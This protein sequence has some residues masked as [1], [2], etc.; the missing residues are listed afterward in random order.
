MTHELILEGCAP[1]PLASYLK[2]IGVLRLVANQVDPEAIGWWSGDRFHLGS[3]LDREELERFLLYDYQPTPIVAPWNGG[4]GFY[5]KDK[6]AREKG[7]DPIVFSKCNRLELYRSILTLCQQVISN[8]GLTE[9][10]GDEIKLR[11]FVELRGDF[12]DEALDWLDAAILL[13]SDDLKFPPLLGTGGNDGRLEFTANFMQRLMSIIDPFT[14][15]PSPEATG[16]LGASLFGYARFHMEKEGIGQFLPGAIGGPNSS[17]NARGGFVVN[18]W[19]YVL[20]L[21]GAVLFAAA[22][23]RRLG[24]S[25]SATLAYP[26]TVRPTGSGSGTTTVGDDTSSRAEIWMPLWSR[27]MGIGELRALLAE[28]RATVGRRSTQDGLDFARATAA[29]G[30][31]RGVDAFERY[32]FFQRSGKAYLATPLTRVPV[33]RNPAMDLVNDLDRRQWLSRFRGMARSKD[34]PARLGRVVRRLEDALFDLARDGSPLRVQTVLAA[35]GKAQSYLAT[36]PK[37]QDKI[38]PVPRLGGRWLA[39][40]DDRSHE[41]RLAAALSGINPATLPLRAHLAPVSPDP[42]KNEWV[43]GS[44]LV[45]WGEGDLERNLVATL[46][47][48]LVE[49]TRREMPDKPLGGW[50]PADLAAVT[51]F[52]AGETDDSRLDGLIAG[53]ALV[54]QRR[55][56]FLWRGIE[57]GAV[58][59]ALAMLAPIFASNE[60]L[61][62]MGA[63][64]PGGRL[65]VP[66]GLVRRLIS[67]QVN[68]ALDGAARCARASGVGSLP[69]GI[70]GEGLNGRRLAASL[71]FPLNDRDLGELMRR[72]YLRDGS[73]ERGI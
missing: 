38:N 22:A 68:L 70:D 31:D 35:L 24:G 59:A 67:G 44:R 53:L 73:D 64:D 19:D 13:T 39:A 12:P 9:S 72:V 34:V 23:T 58:P 55:P 49:A 8:Q 29:L 1:T 62:R 46:E 27:P 52:L 61:R 2:A 26:F 32:A 10:P 14:G 66:P 21:E 51:A 37:H 28:G 16:W 48:R 11:L 33:R 47:R 41:L 60:Q 71:L 50:P 3:A 17:S 65:P 42:K 25:G 43:E 4:S 15:D 63:L 45:V 56:E 18:S 54:E 5:P 36:S 6:G 20:M 40:A 7:L 30:V 57:P 69:S